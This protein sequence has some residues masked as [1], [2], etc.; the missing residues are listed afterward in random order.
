MNPFLTVLIVC[1]IIGF[2]IIG[3]WHFYSNAVAAHNP[4]GQVAIGQHVFKVEFAETL[5]SQQQGLSDRDTMAQ[6]EGMLFIFPAPKISTFWMKS[7][8]FPLDVLWIE[9]GTIVDISRNIPPPSQT[10]GVPRTMSPVAPA[11]MV[12]EINAGL[13]DQLRIN[14]GDTIKIYK[15]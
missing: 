3:V 9:E 13:V 5:A 11:D 4:R 1:A 2:I 10:G 14:T 12:L 7:M 15:D 6:N 8:Q